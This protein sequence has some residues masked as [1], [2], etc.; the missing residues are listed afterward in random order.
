M[1]T[2]IILAVAVVLILAIAL[3]SGASNMG[4]KLSQTLAANGVSKY[5]ALPFYNSYSTQKAAYLYNDIVAAGGTAVNVYN[6]N[7]TAWQRWAGGGLGQINFDLAP[8]IGYQVKSTAAV[9]NWV[10]VGSHNPS[11]TIGLDANGVSKYIAI[12][13]HTTSTS[14]ALFYNELVA[15]GG[16][17][18][19]VYNW[20]GTAWQ[21][22]AGGGLG[23][24]NFAVTPGVAYQAKSTAAIA[25]WTPAHY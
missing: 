13:Y 11:T 2:R 16:T 17:A 22:W 6:W 10:V 23:Q 7:G 12:P 14:A 15:A 21:R 5:I 18:V 19:N 9:D 3:T 4:F 24:V 1:K 8:G 25:A 20:N